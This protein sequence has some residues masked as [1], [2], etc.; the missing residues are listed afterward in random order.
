MYSRSAIVITRA[1]KAERLPSLPWLAMKYGVAKTDWIVFCE[2]G[3]RDILAGN[4]GLWTA[5]EHKLLASVYLHRPGLIAVVG[6]PVGSTDASPPSAGQDEVRRLVERLRWY[7]LPATVVGFWTNQWWG[8]EE[9][10][11]SEAVQP[12]EAAEVVA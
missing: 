10:I 1:A 6:H 12:S 7:S 3:W 5:F 8:L 2:E 11:E 9:V 4:A